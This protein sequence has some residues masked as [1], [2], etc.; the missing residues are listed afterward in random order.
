MRNS[1]LVIYQINNGKPR[2]ATYIDMYYEI[3]G[4]EWFVPAGF[5]TDLASVP[6]PFSIFFPKLGKYARAA[7]LHDYLIEQ[8]VWSRKM[9]DRV[10]I[11][12]MQQDGVGRVRSRLM[13]W[14]V[15]AYAK[16]SGKES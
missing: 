16:L 10:F 9:C 13:Y 1:N 2:V 11:E 5:I 7:V 6:F 4:I 15:R 14:A 8:K 12:C 3:G